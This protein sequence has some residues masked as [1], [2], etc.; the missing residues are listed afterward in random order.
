M[1]EFVD[2]SSLLPGWSCCRCRTYNGLQRPK[3]RRCTVE[4]HA[5][6]IPI[7]VV[8]C[9]CGFGIRLADVPK[10]GRACPVQGCGLPLPTSLPS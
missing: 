1:C 3:C 2:G 9:E 6:T 8:R 7:D 4:R 5:I 10:E